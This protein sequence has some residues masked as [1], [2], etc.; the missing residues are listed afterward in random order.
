MESL[1]GALLTFKTV[2]VFWSICGNVCSPSLAAAVGEE[3]VVCDTSRQQVALLSVQMWCR[4]SPVCLHFKVRWIKVLV[5]PDSTVQWYTF[6]ASVTIKLNTETVDACLG[7]TKARTWNVS[8]VLFNTK[9][10]DAQKHFSYLSIYD[11]LT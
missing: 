1:C 7:L 11:A 5:N 3:R 10:V 8:H 2:F 6:S 4:P 9:N